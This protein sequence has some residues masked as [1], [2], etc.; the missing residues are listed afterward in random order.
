MFENPHRQ[1]NLTL[2][3]VYEDR[4]L[5]VSVDLHLSL[6]WQQHT[7]S[8]QAIRLVYPPLIRKL[9]SSPNPTNKSLTEL[10]LKIQ[11]TVPQ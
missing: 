2:Q 3:L 9:R 6:C 8:E 4:R 10:G 1:P 7:K 11:T 5:F